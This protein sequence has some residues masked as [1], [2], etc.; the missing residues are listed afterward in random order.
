MRIAGILLALLAFAVGVG[1]A[2]TIRLTPE[3]KWFEVL[4]GGGLKAGDEVILTAGTYS[5]RRRLEMNHRGTKEKPIIIR[6]KGAILKRPDARQNSINMAG[7]Q[8]LE[9]HDLEITGGSAGIRIEGKGNREAEFLLFEGLHIHHVGGVAITANNSKSTYQELIFRRNHIHH[10][11]GHGEAFYLGGNNAKDGSTTGV[12]H[13]SVIEENY[14]HHLNGPNVSQGDGI[15]LKDGSHSNIVRNNVIHDTKYPG[16]LVYGTDGNGRNLIEGNVI[17]NTGDSGIQAAA[18]AYV[19]NNIIFNTGGA[20]IYSR[21]HQSA[22]V[23]GL[24]I[25]NNTVVN[26]GK[27]ALRII[28]PEKYSGSIVIANNALYGSIAVQAVRSKW[29]TFVGNAGSGRLQ[30]LN[31]GLVAWDGGGDAAKDFLPGERN[32]FPS[33]DSHL[34]GKASTMILKLDFDGTERSKSRDAG[35]YRVDPKGNP[36][37]QI[38]PGFKQVK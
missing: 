20:G 3:S 15:E 38:A 33:T 5:D 31:L 37:W 19:R 35:A 10:T 7:C 1:S 36:G 9:I 28:P 29:A 25:M 14:I 18:D 23:G 13:H 26:K 6:A 8:W 2:K 11:A 17:W 4:H 24:L 12:V 27:T 32:F 16:I 22:V 30:G 34:I 21:N